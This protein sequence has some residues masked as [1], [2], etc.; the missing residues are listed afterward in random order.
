MWGS[1]TYRSVQRCAATT[2]GYTA[3]GW[4]VDYP[5]LWKPYEHRPYTVVC[6][7]DWGIEPPRM[8]ALGY[9]HA[10]CG[11][12]CVKQG[13]GDWLR[14]LA[15]FPERYAEAE[16][17]EAAMRLNPANADY[18]IVRDQ[19]GGTVRA[20]TLR[21]LRERH[22]TRLELP[23]FAEQLVCLNCGPGELA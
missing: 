5:L 3:H 19:S 9:S 2:K 7:S 14:T 8:Y 20:L 15:N 10:N 22:A 11:G 13:I 23:L 18:A 17:W 12:R 4:E 1:E 21:E 6:R 16:A